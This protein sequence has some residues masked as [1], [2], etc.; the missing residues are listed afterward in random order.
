MIKLK[1]ILGQRTGRPPG[2]NG[3]SGP[4]A[5]EYVEKYIIEPFSHLIRTK[6]VQNHN[7]VQNEGGMESLN[8]LYVDGR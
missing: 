7:I 2:G 6:S 1:N 8:S 5:G 4:E 3:G